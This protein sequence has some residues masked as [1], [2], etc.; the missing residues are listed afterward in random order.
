VDGPS[1]LD[2]Q[3]MELRA[4]TTPSRRRTSTSGKRC[5]RRLVRA[6][7]HLDSP[8]VEAVPVY[9]VAAGQPR[10]ARAQHPAGDSRCVE[11]IPSATGLLG[12]PCTS[13]AR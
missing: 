12:P 5:A 9:G 11:D 13:A 2:T 6:I 4:E 1:W 3:S 10:N 7:P 8:R